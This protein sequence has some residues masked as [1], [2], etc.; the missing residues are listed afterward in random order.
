MM[1]VIMQIVKHLDLIPGELVIFIFGV[2][3]KDY[4]FE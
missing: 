2:T 3:D 4:S 1:Y